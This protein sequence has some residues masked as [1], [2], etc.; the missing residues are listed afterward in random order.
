MTVTREELGLR[1]E[2]VLYT[3][4]SESCPSGDAESKL[5]QKVVPQD[6]ESFV[7]Q[8][9]EPL[10]AHVIF[11]KKFVIV[12]FILKNMVVHLLRNEANASSGRVEMLSQHQWQPG[13]E[14]QTNVWLV[15]NLTLVL[16]SW[17][18]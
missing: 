7:Q 17:I 3:A 10:S 16:V 13:W 11:Y 2:W 4:G 9:V 15:Q 12:S 1:Y 14:A 6:L 8:N 18:S 5:V